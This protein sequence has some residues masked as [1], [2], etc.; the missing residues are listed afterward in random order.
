MNRRLPMLCIQFDMTGVSPWNPLASPA[1]EPGP[2]AGTIVEVDPA[3]NGGK[4]C[5][6]TVNLDD[7]TETNL[8]IGNEPGEKGGNKK[9]WRTALIA[10]ATANGAPEE[11]ALQATAGVVNFDPVQTFKGKKIHLLVKPV[12]GPK[13]DQGRDP[14]PDK[15]FIT[16]AQFNALKASGKIPTA[17]T[18][19]STPAGATATG[20]QTPSGTPN[21]TGT[22]PGATPAGGNV[23]AG[24]FG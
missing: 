13:D 3:Y 24:L 2:H 9:K 4:S 5:A 14:L 20:G 21:G 19:A 18:G 22:A 16:L 10:V 12:T 6:F 17:S 11:K 1:P 8:F 15:E 23:L 7:G